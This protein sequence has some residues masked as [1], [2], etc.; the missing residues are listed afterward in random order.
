MCL[1]WS[2]PSN[3]NAIFSDFVVCESY[4]SQAAFM[5]KE[6]RVFIDGGEIGSVIQD[7]RGKFRFTYDD[8]CGSEQMEGA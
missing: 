3:D 7:V 2:T 1:V 4:L 8:A 5:T 6:L